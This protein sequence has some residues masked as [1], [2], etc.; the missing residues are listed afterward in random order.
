M[1]LQF[2][3]GKGQN[4]NGENH[5]GGARVGDRDGM[6]Q[7]VVLTDAQ[8][9]LID[10][11]KGKFEQD[12]YQDDENGVSLDYALYVPEN[13]D[14][15]KEYPLIMFIPDSSAAGK[16]TEEVLS[17]YYGSDILASDAEQE[18]HASFV[19]C[20]AFSETVVDDSFSTS[21]QIDTAMKVLNEMIE[22]Y[23][24]DTSRIYTT[25]QSMGCMT[26]LYVNGKYP[27]L[28]AA[29]LFVSGQWDISTLKLLENKKFFY[30]TCSGD[31]KASGGQTEVMD[32]LKK[33]GIS[34]SYIE[35][36]DPEASAEDKTAQVQKMLE[37]GNQANFIRFDGLDHMTSFNYAYDLEAV[38]DWL[39]AQS[40]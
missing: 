31:Q 37:E 3:L 22:K 6:N 30:V 7:K 15:S 28:F 10:A 32:M 33:D 24:I 11:T 29:S 26:S 12:S 35:N 8:Q 20:P 13:Y 34:Y 38:R 9:E 17:Q 18:K 40:K 2:V 4:E 14:A 23:S 36:M 16:S 25:G 39:F 1:P 27:D 21:N 19:F 5:T